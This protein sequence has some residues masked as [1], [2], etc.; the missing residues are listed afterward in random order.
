MT[1]VVLDLTCDP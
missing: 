1:R